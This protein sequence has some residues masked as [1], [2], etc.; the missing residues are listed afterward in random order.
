MANESTQQTAAEIIALE[1][2]VILQTYKR[3][4]FVFERGEGVTL[5]D[6]NGKAYLDFAAGIAVNALG[7]ADP[8]VQAAIED[9]AKK[10]IHVSNLFHTR[11]QVELAQLL[12]EK[13]FADRVFLCNSG[14]EAIEAAIKFSR[15]WARTHH[16]ENEQKYEIVSFT[17]AFHG[18]TMGALAVTPR[19]SYQAPFR[20]L[21]PGVATGKFNDL[22]SAAQVIGPNTAA[23]IVEPVQGEGGINSATK[24]FLQGLRRLCDQN[25]AALIFD[26]IQCGLGRTGLLWAHEGLGVTPDLMTLAKPLA[27]GLP[28]GA[29]LMTNAV[30]EVMKPGDH[31]STFAA[32]PLVTH[33][34][35]VVFRRIS[36]PR[37][38]AHVCDVGGYL[39]ESLHRLREQYPAMI[40]EIRGRGLIWGIDLGVPAADVIQQ[41]YAQGLVTINA[42]EKVLR[43]VPPLVITRKNV[44]TLVEKLGLIF[45]QMEVVK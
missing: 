25:Q 2:Q 7:Y 42:G 26:E 9:Q 34:A 15:K 45:T 37:F 35:T 22:D 44:D 33:V 29:V 5:Y 32:N 41:G 20:P 24:E 19:E 1:N 31:G 11:P 38:L 17:G 14:T 16:P 30:A 12:V 21:M 10:L 36:D 43:L 13:S 27:N 23:V 18:R 6:T 3:A 4:P 39:G 8:E 40:H 28:I